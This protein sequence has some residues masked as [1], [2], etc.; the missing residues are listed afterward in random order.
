MINMLIC[1]GGVSAAPQLEN[2]MTMETNADSAYRHA[3]GEA[4]LQVEDQETFTADDVLLR[5]DAIFHHD[6]LAGLGAF[7]ATAK[8]DLLERMV[9]TG[10]IVAL[11]T[12]HLQLTA[13]GREMQGHFRLNYLQMKERYRRILT[14]R[15]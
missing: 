5:A 12:G 10:S 15:C 3:L 14:A 2:A 11:P 13:L 6:H 4:L 7:C 9:K 8:E 1:Y